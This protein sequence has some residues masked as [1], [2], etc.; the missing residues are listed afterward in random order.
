MKAKDLS[1]IGIIAAIYAVLTI[2]L[3]PISYGP[4]QFRLSETMKPLALRGKNEI[5]GLTIG[6]LLANLFSPFSG[7]W[8]L[9]FMPLVAL[10]GGY[11]TYYLRS[12]KYLAITFYSLWIAGGVSIVLYMVAGLPI[13]ATFPGIFISELILMWLGVM[14]IENI[15]CRSGQA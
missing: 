3:S 10:T 14:F 1:K 12:I 11:I 4:L 8:E 13:I 5:L 6:L 15:L 2:L 9:L 7:P